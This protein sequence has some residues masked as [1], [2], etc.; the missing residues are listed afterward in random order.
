MNT[1]PGIRRGTY[2]E[3]VQIVIFTIVLEAATA[4]TGYRVPGTW[5]VFI[6]LVL[7]LARR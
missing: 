4:G 2:K 7:V 1:V 5:Q 3:Y 6:R